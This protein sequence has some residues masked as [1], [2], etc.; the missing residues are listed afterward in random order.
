VRATA[1]RTKLRLALDLP[2]AGT[3]AILARRGKVTYA[4]KRTAVPAGRVTVTLTP[5]R[6]GRAAL[7]HRKRLA[8]TVS[9]TYTP[10]RGAASTQARKVTVRKRR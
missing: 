4:R 6:A 10:A 9:A 3:L 8:L 1:A 7:K 2:Q 5:S